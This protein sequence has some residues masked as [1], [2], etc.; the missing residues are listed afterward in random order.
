VLRRNHGHFS[1]KA[2][3]KIIHGEESENP[4]EVECR[5]TPKFKYTPITSMDFEKC[6]TAY[7]LV[8]GKKRHEYESENTENILVIY[9]A[10]KYG[11]TYN[12][13]SLLFVF[14]VTLTD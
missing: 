14:L 5:N 11:G 1:E 12:F 7:K 2:L 6:F 10:A 8:P 13:Q 4:A 3:S 9:C